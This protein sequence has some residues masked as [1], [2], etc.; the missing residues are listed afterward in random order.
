M[1]PSKPP[2]NV[3]FEVFARERITTD[4]CDEGRRCEPSP[5]LLYG[6]SELAAPIIIEIPADPRMFR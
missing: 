3:N 6:Y 1:P 4:A 5:P 2:S